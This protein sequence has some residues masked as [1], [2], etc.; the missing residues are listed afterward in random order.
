MRLAFVVNG[1]VGEQT[2]D[3]IL[4]YVRSDSDFGSLVDVWTFNGGSSIGS[5]V[6]LYDLSGAPVDPWRNPNVEEIVVSKGV[7]LRTDKL[8]DRGIAVSIHGYHSLK[9]NKGQKI[10]E[11]LRKNQLDWWSPKLNELRGWDYEKIDE[12][13]VK[14]WLRQFAH[15]GAED[16]ALELLR[17]TTVVPA[18]QISSALADFSRNTADA[19]GVL[20]GINRS[21]GRVSNLIRDKLDGEVPGIADTI[22]LAASR[23][24]KAVIFEDGALDGYR[25]IKGPEY[26]SG[27][28]FNRQN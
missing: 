11:F 27:G 9:K 17:A 8:A 16:Q 2:R 28:Q 15:F 5:N 20:S 6:P 13:R 26:S 7:S 21:G 23:G 25:N 1:S 19:V 18:H 24:T 4:R 12:A 3:L 10:F 22:E 14:H